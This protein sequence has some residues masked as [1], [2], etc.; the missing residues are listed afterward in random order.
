MLSAGVEIGRDK[1]PYAWTFN[2]RDGPHR[3][4]QK[5]LN[6]VCLTWQTVITDNNC[7]LVLL[8]RFLRF[9]APLYDQN[10]TLTLKRKKIEK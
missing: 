2:R 5:G 7:D 1:T 9:V 10:N 4:Q 3:N 6:H 8:P